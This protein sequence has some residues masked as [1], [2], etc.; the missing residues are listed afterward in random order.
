[1]EHL[2]TATLEDFKDFTKKF[3]HPNNAVLV[4]AG[5]FEKKPPKKDGSKTLWPH[6]KAS[7]V[8]KANVYRETDN[9]ND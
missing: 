6:R 3:K 7:E 4:V 9:V 2:D 5:D 8:L 1:M